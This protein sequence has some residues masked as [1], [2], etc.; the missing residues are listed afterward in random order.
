LE[1]GYKPSELAEVEEFAVI[2]ETYKN[3]YNE[4]LKKYVK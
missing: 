4:L 3:E 2:K 1:V